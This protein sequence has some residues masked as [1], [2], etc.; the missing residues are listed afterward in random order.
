[1]KIKIFA[2]VGSQEFQFDRLIKALDMLDKNKYEI[3]LQSGYSTFFPKNFPYSKFLSKEDFLKKIS[4][5]DL[6]ITH[7]G[8]GAIIN[9]LTANKPVIAVARLKKY[10]EHV[11]DHQLEIL[12]TFV[13]KNYICGFAEILDL[14]N[15]IDFAL[16]ND[17]A[18]FESNTNNFV[19]NLKIIINN[20]WVK[21]NE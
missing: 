20:F 3:F 18:T 14:D 8:T 21:C 2:T 11:D 15:K 12:N 1:M 13:Q 17:F 6:I 9:S 16:N 7:A 10:G 4:E 5:C 19:T